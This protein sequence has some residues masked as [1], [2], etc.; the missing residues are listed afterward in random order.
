MRR[1]QDSWKLLKG[2]KCGV[3]R[4]ETTYK[5]MPNK[6]HINEMNSKLEKL[7]LIAKDED[8]YFNCPISVQWTNYMKYAIKENTII[9]NKTEREI[10]FIRS[11]NKLTERI[12][13]LYLSK[14]TGKKATCNK[15]TE[16]FK[17]NLCKIISYLAWKK[18][19][20]NLINVEKLYDENHKLDT[21]NMN[22]ISYRVDE[23][24]NLLAEYMFLTNTSLQYWK[25]NNKFTH[26]ITNT[27]IVD[28]QNY[29]FLLP[30]PN[31]ITKLK[32]YP[33]P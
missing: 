3:L 18:I 19:P 32:I 20:I 33:Y 13:G 29:K 26:D 16:A 14:K 27:G 7:L 8:A 23:D 24:K 11:V 10:L 2:E 6:E 12:N 31:K 22:L 4:L 9:I 17:S 28:L 5:I 1:T 15:N 25:P 30:I 21:I